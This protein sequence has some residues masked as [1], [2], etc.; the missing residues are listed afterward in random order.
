MFK[1]AER[2]FAPQ[3]RL[4]VVLTGASGFYMAARLHAWSWF[5][6]ARY[7][8]MDAMVLLWT[9]FAGLLFIVEPLLFHRCVAARAERDPE[10]ALRLP[11]RFHWVLLL[12]S[13]PRLTF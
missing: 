8:W 12:L 10:G 6:A 13:I 3:A 2:R 4:W 1:A 5:A 9:L 7:W 11:G